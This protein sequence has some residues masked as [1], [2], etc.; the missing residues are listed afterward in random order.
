MKWTCVTTD[1]LP[2]LSLFTVLLQVDELA[3]GALGSQ[4]VHPDFRLWLTSMPSSVFPVPV[5]QN[6]IKLTNEPPKGVKANLARSYNQ[7]GSDVLYSCPSKPTEWKRLL[8]SLTMFHAVVQVCI[9][10]AHC[11]SRV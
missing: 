8:F 3:H 11:D 5:L 1:A 9:G 4:P 6:G 10:N 2:S 7:L